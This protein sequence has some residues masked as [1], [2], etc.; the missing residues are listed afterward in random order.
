MWCG[1]YGTVAVGSSFGLRLVKIALGMWENKTSYW[2]IAETVSDLFGVKG[3]AKSTI[4]HAVDAAAAAAME[5]EFRQI[6]A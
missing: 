1:A 3:Y 5:P 2:D 6:K 4:Q